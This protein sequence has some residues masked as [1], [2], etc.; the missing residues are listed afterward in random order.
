[1]KILILGSTG[2]IG[3]NLKTR[4]EKE[5]H[6]IFTAEKSSGVDIRN[7]N[8]INATSLHDCSF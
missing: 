7:Y 4:L 5:G 2:F 3:S 8:D 6:I 1:M